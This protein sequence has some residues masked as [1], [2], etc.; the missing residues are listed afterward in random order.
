MMPAMRRLARL[1]FLLLFS[2]FGA[3]GDPPAPAPPPR[4]PPAPP[5]PEPASAPPPAPSPVT[6]SSDTPQTTDAGTTFTGPAGWTVLKTGSRIT[7]TGQEQDLRVAVVEASE[8]SADDAVAAAWRAV[9]PDFKRPLRVTKPRPGRRGWDERRSYE[10]ETSPDEKL[11]VGADAFRHGTK[12]TV[13][14]LESSDASFEKRLAQIIRIGDTLRPEGYV[15]ESFAGKKAHDLDADR[16]K[17]ITGTVDKLRELAGIPGIGFALVQH[18][19]VIYEGGSGVRELGKPEKVDAK[20]LFIIASNTKALTTLL[21]AKLVDEKKLEW[22]TP[23]NTLYP[24]FKLG[25]ADTTKKVLVEHLVCACTGLPRQDFEWLF[26]FEKQSPKT[27]M[28]TLGTMQPTTKFGETFQYSNPLAAAAGFVAGHVALP[29]KELG[30]AYDEAMQ[31]RVFGPL[32]MSDTT[33]EFA[34]ALH[35]NHAM[36]F[37]DDIDGKTA[38]AVMELNKSIVAVRPAGGAWSS[39]HDMAKYVAMEL[40]RGKLADG[41]PYIAE[42]PLLARRKPQVKIGEFATYGMALMVDNEWGIEV[43]HHG[44]DIVGYHSDMF[45][46]PEADVGGVIL[47]NGNGYLVRR[48]IIRKTVEALYDGHAEAEEDAA[49]GVASHKAEIVVERKRLTVPPDADIV[50]KLAKKYTSPAIGDIVVTANGAQRTFD[51]GGWKSP[52]ASRKNDDGT[53]SLV[54]IAPGAAGIPFVVGEK[55]GKKTLVVRDM[56][57][58]YVFTA[59]E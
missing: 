52:I 39:V 27:V 10:Y 11:V 2:V 41:K 46:I 4:L 54:T 50:S 21:L 33:F 16:T 18:G 13:V 44:G 1:S 22:K 58:E 12:W 45:W 34:R 15:R 49:A 25:D 17:A 51:F 32:G 42:E 8:A 48:A 29:N 35:G 24:S 20:T 14:L 19:K 31:T 43:V 53:I 40:A 36:P 26:E 9:R 38:P 30:A 3:C 5:P 7:M 47:T 57:H 23:V 28:D 59:S 37:A 56:Q 6:L 55:N